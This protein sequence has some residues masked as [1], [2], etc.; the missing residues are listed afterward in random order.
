[1]RREYL[2]GCAIGLF[3]LLAGCSD[4]PPPAVDTSAADQKAIK[5]GEVAWNA[6][7]ASKDLEKILSHYADDGSALM[8]DSPIMKGKDAIRAGFKELLADKNLSLNFAADTVEV[9]SKG[10]DLGYTQGT[11]SMTSTN[12]KTKKPETE[13]GKYVTVYKKQ[14]DGVWKAVED[15]YNADAPPVPVMA[16]KAK[17][18]E[19]AAR[20][21]KKK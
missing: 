21:R 14:A 16:A 12:R 11:Y 2:A 19:P 10:G 9:S 20:R 6:D 17:R 8:P 13:K 15:I 3:I 7:F 18:A 1:M 5:D 4:T